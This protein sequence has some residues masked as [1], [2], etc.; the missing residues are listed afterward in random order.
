V[1]PD[2]LSRGRTRVRV[3]GDWGSDFGLRVGRIDRVRQL[4]YFVDGEHRSAALQVDHGLGDRWTVEA[5]LAVLW[6]GG[7]SLDGLIDAWHRLTGLP[8]ND[9]PRYPRDQLSL[10]GF[11]AEDD[12]VTWTG[13]EGTGLGGVELGARWSTA[14]R[15]SGWTA[16][17]ESRVQLPTG[18]GAFAD[19]GSQFGAQALAA[20]TLGSAGDAYFGMGATVTSRAEQGGLQYVSVRPQ[21]FLALEWRP[22]RAVSLL[23]QLNAAGR[24]VRNLEEFPGLHLVLRMGAKVDVARGWRLEAGFTEGLKPVDATTDFGVLLGLERTF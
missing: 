21:G 18:T 14:P 10:T 1:A 19:A 16:A 7:G 5:R 22:G 15:D 24:L 6:R 13:P 17:F 12:A 8:D 9:R 3:A 23:A 4:L 11:D 20:G 2:A